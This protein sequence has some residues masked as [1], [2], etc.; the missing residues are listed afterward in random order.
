MIIYVSFF[1]FFLA[2]TNLIPAD[3]LH[4]E[5]IETKINEPNVIFAHLDAV[6][7]AVRQNDVFIIAGNTVTLLNVIGD[8]LADQLDASG[9][10][11]RAHAAALAA[12]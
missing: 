4:R 1:F 5:I 3:Y 2:Y 10:R 12:L 6:G 9:F 11:V 7:S 8:M